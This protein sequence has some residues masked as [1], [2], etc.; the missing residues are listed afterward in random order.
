MPKIHATLLIRFLLKNVGP[1]SQFAN[2]VSSGPASMLGTLN[3]LLPDFWFIND[4]VA[5]N[6]D[7][8]GKSK[9]TLKSLLKKI[10]WKP[11]SICHLWTSIKGQ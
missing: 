10:Q 3:G 5:G 7:F 9:K 6:R 11:F 4:K 8:P 2:A 1:P